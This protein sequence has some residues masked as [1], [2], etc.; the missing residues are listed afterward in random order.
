MRI[1]YLAR[2]KQLYFVRWYEYFIN[3][4]HEV[5]VVSGDDRLI[6][7]DV[8]MPAGVNVHYVPEIKLRNQVIS[9]GY[10]LLR[11]PLIIKELKKVIRNISPDIIHAHQ[12]TPSGLWA[13]LSNCHPFIITPMGSDVIVQARENLFYKSI[14]KYVLRKADL[15]TSDS[16]TLQEAVFELGGRPEKTHVIQNGVDFRV[17]NPEVDKTRIRRELSL[18]SSPVILSTRGISPL[19]NIDCIVGAIPKVLQYFP[20]ARF[21]FLFAYVMEDSIIKVKE[22]VK[23]LGVANAVRFIGFVNHQEMPF[24]YAAADILVSVPS[25]DSSPCSVYEA[26]ACRTPVVISDLPWTKHFMRNGENAVIVS[27]KKPEAIA[28]AILD[29]LHNDQLK[30]RLVDGGL[31][32]VEMYVDYQ[33]NMEMMENLMK[34]LIQNN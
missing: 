31:S 2:A 6:N 30:N 17:F 14:T 20:D 23:R 9:F 18:G 16:I 32:T 24:Y 13:A 25:S 4:G 15:I 33:R 28:D 11:L 21:L 3:R 34:K 1:C 29:V 8:E 12:I 22:L 27:A 26:M 7:L 19:Y 5:H 10:N